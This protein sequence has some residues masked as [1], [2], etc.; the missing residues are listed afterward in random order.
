MIG[1]GQDNAR[2][3]ILEQV[4]RRHTLY[5]ALRADRHEHRRLYR[6]VRGVQQPR[7]GAGVRAGGLNLEVQT[8]LLQSRS[9]RACSVFCWLRW[10]PDKE[11]IESKRAICSAI[12]PI[13]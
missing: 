8:L 6:S 7:A 9:C 3:Q 2:I 13:S 1:I 10:P 5:G 4:A 12:L 11:S